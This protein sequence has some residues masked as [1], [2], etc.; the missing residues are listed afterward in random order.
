MRATGC[1]N[2]TQRRHSVAGAC[3]ARGSAPIGLDGAVCMMMLKPLFGWR[4]TQTE[5]CVEEL[6]SWV[7]GWRSDHITVQTS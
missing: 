4:R 2:A 7:L 1:C 3:G 5:R 6:S